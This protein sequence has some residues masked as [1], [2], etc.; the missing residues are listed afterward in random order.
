MRSYL[1]PL[2]R[3]KSLIDKHVSAEVLS[4]PGGR[5]CVAYAEIAA[6]LAQAYLCEGWLEEAKESFHTAI[7]FEMISQGYSWPS[8]EIS[9]IL[10]LGLA[11]ACQK[12]GDLEDAAELLKSALALSEKLY[13]EWDLRTAAILSHLKTVSDKRETM[14]QHHKSAVVA[15]ADSKILEEIRQTV[16]TPD[17]APARIFSS[18]LQTRDNEED[19]HDQELEERADYDTDTLGASSE[20]DEGVV[21]LLVARDDVKA[22]SKDNDGQTPLS[23]AVQRG[24]EAVVKL[25]RS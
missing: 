5:F 14:L 20:G 24:H 18:A 8:T 13:D 9:L 22:D 17:N 1:A 16:R 25:L 7:E 3:C 23:W 11:R 12:S 10:L 2:N 6:H 15:A 21:K 4:P 19:Y